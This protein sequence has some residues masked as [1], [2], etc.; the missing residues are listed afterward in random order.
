MGLSFL[1]KPSASER[2]TRTS[3]DFP[4]AS[5]VKDTTTVPPSFFLR[6]WLVNSGSGAYTSFGA[7]TPSP[8]WY[9]PA[10]SGFGLGATAWWSASVFPSRSPDEADRWLSTS[11]G[12]P[13]G[14]EAA[15]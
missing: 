9:L 13:S 2:E 8:T 14:K 7:E 1:L 3:W 10:A 15:C 11:G 4:A 12:A 5:T 6:A